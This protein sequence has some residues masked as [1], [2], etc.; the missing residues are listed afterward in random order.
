MA[1][2]RK[3]FYFLEKSDILSDYLNKK[4]GM[5]FTLSALMSN[6]PTRNWNLKELFSENN[7]NSVLTK[8]LLTN[9]CF[10]T[11]FHFISLTLLME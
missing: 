3:G 5:G 6:I 7:C 2:S 9:H 8:R 1:N 4:K 10:K 11:V